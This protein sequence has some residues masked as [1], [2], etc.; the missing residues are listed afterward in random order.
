MV[1]EIFNNVRSLGAH[2]KMRTMMTL[3][4]DQEVMYELW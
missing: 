3:M 4:G 2:H 1:S